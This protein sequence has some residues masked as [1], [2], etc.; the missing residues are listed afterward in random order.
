MKRNYRTPGLLFL[1]AL[2]SGPVIVNVEAA[3]LAK[4]KAACEDC[5][6]KDGAS[7]EPKIPTIGG[8]SATY[9]T[10]AMAAYADKSWPCEAVK[11]PAGTKKG[12]TAN[13]CDIAA[14]LSEDETKLLADHYASKPFVR[15]KQAFNAELAK[16]GKGIHDLECKKCHEDGGTSPDDDA[17]M[18]GGQ[19][20]PY[21][22][23]QF[24]EYGEG[25]RPMTEKMQAKMKKLTADDIKALLQYYASIQ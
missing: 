11:Y 7:T 17:G 5:H 15:A 21:L 3:D 18:L 10:D 25:K 2:L 13:M 9:I 14:K 19:W 8:F 12:E 1:G 20:T 22:E 6:G 16:R 24:E 4:L 23:E